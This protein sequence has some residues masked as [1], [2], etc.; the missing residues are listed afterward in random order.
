M[1]QNQTAYDAIPYP[2]APF[3][4]SHPE[5]LAAV[6][7]LFGLVAPAR[8][9]CRVLELG[10]SMGGNLLAIAQIH[11]DAHLL[12]VDASSHQIAEGSK[13]IQALGLENVRLQHLDILDIGED[14]G[15]FDY[16]ISHGVYSWVPA[17]V[18]NRMLEVCKRHL[19]PGGVAYLSHNTYPGWHVRGI[20]RDMML[21]RGS[22]FA[23]PAARLEQAK[24]LV[25]FVAQS[26]RNEDSPYKRL[27]KSELEV[28]GSAQDYYLHHDHLEE[29]NH[30]VY[31]HEFARRL[32]ENGLQ[33]LGDAD[34][35]TMVPMN[36]PPEVAK[37]LHAL[38]AHDIVQMEQYMDFVR[39]RYFRKTLICHRGVRLTR[40]IDALIV[41]DLLLASGVTPPNGKDPLDPA[42]SVTYSMPGGR[43]LTCRSPITKLALRA[44]RRAWPM[45]VAFPEL[46]A[47]CAVEA[48]RE[49]HAPDP[50]AGEDFLATELL[51]AI[52]AGVVEWRTTPVPYTTVIAGK[53]A[54]SPLARLQAAQG[55]KATNLRGEWVTLD[56]IHR[57]ALMRLDGTRTRDGLI[58]ALVRA[59]QNRE[60][61]LHEENDPSK[62]LTGE[63]AMRALL[64]TAID[65]VLANLA[66]KAFLARDRA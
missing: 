14:F 37:T 41:K 46:Y 8:E 20:V 27:L 21:Y 4:E 51:T 61:L 40:A 56:E 33:Y 25:A 17:T 22:Q 23:D 50:R 13:T 44:L 6:A 63:A 15:E 32:A 39:C 10:C 65:R 12:G 2:S 34:F 66:R 24:S 11:P 43:H 38:G 49:G 30:P 52:G 62:P 16:I 1:A 35:Q 58:D 19:A 42:V 64:G 26:I 29:N 9:N 31:F 54:T 36:F 47:G 60:F 48:Q 3:P 53:P 59:A 28:L 45:P 18:Q 5:R 57:R 7:K 55:R